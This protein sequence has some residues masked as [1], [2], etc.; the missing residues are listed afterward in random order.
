[1]D[2]QPITDAILKAPVSPT[3][4]EAASPLV[5]AYLEAMA[6]FPDTARKT[7]AVEVPW[8]LWLDEKTLVVGVIDRL[9]QDER[10]VFGAEWKTKGAPKLK[11]DG[12]PYAGS[13]EEDWLAEISQGVQVGIYALA[14][15]DADFIFPAAVYN[16]ADW[17]AG[18]PRILVRACIKSDPPAFWPT[19]PSRGIF[20]FEAAYLDSVRA[21]LLSKAAQIRAA[22]NSVRLLPAYPPVSGVTFWEKNKPWQLPGVHCTN[23]Y[24]RTCEFLPLCRERKTP[25]GNPPHAFD[26]SNPAYPALD[27]LNLEPDTVVLS[28]SSYADYAWCIERGRIISGGYF[29]KEPSLE[30]EIGTAYHA[31][32]AAIYSQGMGQ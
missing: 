4:R 31:A 1:M 24:R 29:D 16:P 26:P 7:L 14:L 15:R 3:A 19:D 21:A 28:A 25:T 17:N 30:L 20:S 18:P 5:D 13:S 27:G 32:L 2:T 6:S 11:K 9:A 10:G 22:R 23:M 12:T 8:R